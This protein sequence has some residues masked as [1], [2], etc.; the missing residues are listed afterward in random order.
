M[1]DETLAQM[2]KQPDTVWD[3]LVSQNPELM[4]GVDTM[5]SSGVTPEWICMRPDFL[6]MPVG[7]QTAIINAFHWRQDGLLKDRK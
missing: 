6:D 1:S 2:A 4:K 7:I 5:L 3:V